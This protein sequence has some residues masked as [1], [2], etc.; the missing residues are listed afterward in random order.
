M[1][2]RS[3]LCRFML[4]PL[5]RHPGMAPADRSAFAREP[6]FAVPFVLNP[7]DSPAD[8][9]AATGCAVPQLASGTASILLLPF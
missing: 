8:D 6:T 2:Q 1:Q 3:D 7:R 4:L 5:S 9:I